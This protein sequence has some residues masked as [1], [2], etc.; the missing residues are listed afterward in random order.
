MAVFIPS[1]LLNIAK[2]VNI[3]LDLN[4]L[5]DRQLKNIQNAVKRGVV[6]H[7]SRAATA[8]IARYLLTTYNAPQIKFST[9]RFTWE[10]LTKDN[11]LFDELVSAASLRKLEIGSEG[12]HDYARTYTNDVITV[13]ELRR[14]YDSIYVHYLHSADVA[15]MI[16]TADAKVDPN[17]PVFD[18]L[19]DIVE[20]KETTLK[21]GVEEWNKLF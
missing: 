19:K 3:E 2:D 4:K 8:I 13:A 18:R 16:K 10:G 12:P 9:W 21:I 20:R 17:N 5:S 15:R 7:W 11:P 6:S 1:T 14:P